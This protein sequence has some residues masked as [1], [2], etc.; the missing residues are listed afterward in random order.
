MH[1][2]WESVIMLLFLALAFLPF[3]ALSREIFG[4]G[5][6]YTPSDWREEFF[7]GFLQI[8]LRRG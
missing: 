4:K 6:T 7:R 2:F 5:Y 1:V 3:L 8:L